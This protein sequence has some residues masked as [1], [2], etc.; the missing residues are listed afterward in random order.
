M[1]TYYYSMVALDVAHAR[2]IEADRQHMAHIL[3]RAEGPSAI[4]RGLAHGLA[5]LS[6]GSAEIARRLDESTVDDTHRRLATD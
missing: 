4:R 1:N 3:A 2:T 6:R 5:A